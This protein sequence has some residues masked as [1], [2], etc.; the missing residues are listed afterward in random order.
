MFSWNNIFYVFISDFELAFIYLHQLFLILLQ[1]NDETKNL[2]EIY[3]IDARAE[4]I[5]C[6]LP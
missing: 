5:V 2:R 6:F 1:V 3:D 4:N